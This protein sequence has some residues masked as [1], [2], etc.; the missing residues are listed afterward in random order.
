MLLLQIVLT[1]NLPLLGLYIVIMC[2]ILLILV[3]GVINSKPLEVRKEDGIT[4]PLKRDKNG[5][6]TKLKND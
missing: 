1:S 4:L 3:N 5:K 2:G 6:F